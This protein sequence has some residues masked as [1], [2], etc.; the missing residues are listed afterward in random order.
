ME[1]WRA[2]LGYEGIY[3]VSDAG[4]VRRCDSY[5]TKPR[6]ALRPAANHH[7]YLNVSLSRK[8]EGQAHEGR[9][10]FVHRLVAQAFIGPRPDGYTINHKNGSKTDNRPCN[11]EYVTHQENMRHAGAELRVMGRYGKRN[12]DI[13][14][15]GELHGSS[16]LNDEKVRTVLELLAS[17]GLQQREIAAIVG[18]SQTQIWRIK[19]GL[20]WAHISRP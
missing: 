2:V 20:S 17:G 18:I 13:I 14:L 12:P 4:R 3:E 8:R 16:K 5:H 10:H 19:T 9:T 15:R 1:T 11:L 6:Q 7:G